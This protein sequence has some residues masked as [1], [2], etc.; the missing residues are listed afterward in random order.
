MCPLSFNTIPPF[1][2][3]AFS[4]LSF[5]APTLPYPTIPMLP[6][7]QTHFPLPIITH[8]CLLATSHTNGPSS[9]S[10]HGS[11]RPPSPPP[12]PPPPPTNLP[13]PS[14]HTINQPRRSSRPMS[15]SKLRVRFA[16]ARVLIGLGSLL[17]GGYE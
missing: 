1:F 6:Q 3:P 9:K 17:S 15:R 10:P 4:F 7:T 2:A 11:L 16:R 13:M 5:P 8:Y 12:T 14:L